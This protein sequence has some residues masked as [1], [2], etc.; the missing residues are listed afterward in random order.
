MNQGFL[1]QEPSPPSQ[2]Q[3]SNVH[4]TSCRTQAWH[5]GTQNLTYTPTLPSQEASEAA[6]VH[7]GQDSS[8]AATWTESE[9]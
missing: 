4:S 6:T 2:E 5:V 7:S 8:S 1:K 9:L 3:L